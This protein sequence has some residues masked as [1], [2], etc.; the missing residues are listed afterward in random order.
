MKPEDIKP[1]TVIIGLDSS[2]AATVVVVTPLSDNAWEIVYRLPDRSIRDRM[3]SSEDVA[4]FEE[5]KAGH[6]FGF[7]ADPANFLLTCE[8]KRMDLAFLFDPMMAI[9]TSNVEPLPHQISAVYESMLPRQPLRYV[10]ADDPGA[11]KTIMAGLYMREMILR[12]DAIRILIVAPGSLVEQWRDELYEKFSLQFEVFTGNSQ[13]N[14]VS[15]FQ[16]K[17]QWI[18]RL[19]Q[20]VRNEV[21]QQDLLKEPWDLVIFD[22]AHKL[23]A[24]AN[25]AKIQETSRYKLG[26]ELAKVT[27]H[28]LLMTATP[29][30]GKEADF[31]LFLKLLDED[32]FY[33]KFRDGVHQI[34]PSDLMRRMVKEELVKFDGT[35]LFPERKAY[36][37]NYSLSSAEAK[38]YGLVTQYV[39]SEMGKA[40]QIADGSKRGAVGFALT[41]LQRRLASSP[42]AIYKSLQR[43]CDRHT[44]RLKEEALGRRAQEISLTLEDEDDYTAEELEQLSGELIDRASTAESVQELEREIKILSQLVELAKT[45]NES[46][47]D[48][49]WEELSRI[50]QNDSFMRDSS[51]NRRKIIVFTEHRDTL[52]YLERKISNLLGRPESVA[53]I[54]GGTNRDE[55]RKIQALFRS[56]PDL[57]VLLATDAA[58]E[59]VNLQCACLMVNYDLPWNPNRMEQRFGRIHRI[60]QTEVCHLWSLVA[61]E[62]REGAVWRRLLDKIA[63]ECEALRGKVFNILGEIFEDKPLKDLMI[64]AIRYGELPEVREKLNTVI[65]HAFDPDNLRELLNRNALAEDVMSQENLYRI[66]EEM[67][68]AEA[69]KLQPYY[70][71]LFFEQAAKSL[72]VSLNKRSGRRLEVSFVPSEIRE[73]DRRITGRSRQNSEPV[74]KKYELICFEKSDRDAT[75]SLQSRAV[76]MHPG[77]PLMLAMTDLVLERN[78]GILRQGTILYQ[79]ASEETRPWILVLLSHEVKDGQ[80][81]LL[82]RR[83]QF[84]R[85]DEDGSITFAGYAPHLDLAPIPVEY[86][87]SLGELGD[88]FQSLKSLQD[89][90]IQRITSLLAKEHYDEIKTRHVKQIDKTL[91]AIH[92]RLR[93]EID[94]LTD[95]EERLREDKAAG[96]DVH[97]LEKVQRDLLELNFRLESRS[98]ELKQKRDVVNSTPQILGAALVLPPGFFNTVKNPEQKNRAHIEYLAM[99]AVRYK[100]EQAGHTVIDVSKEHCG[101]DLTSLPR[102]PKGLPRHIEVKGRAYGSDTVTLTR[103]E[104][105]Y[106]LN[107]GD[108]FILAIVLVHPDDTVAGPYYIHKPFKNEPEAGAVSINYHLGDLL[109]KAKVV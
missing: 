109:K 1:G 4:D 68:K 32:R 33:G 31:Q 26:R 14:Y 96:K 71:R 58:G 107:Q 66:K 64:E 84:V 50:L 67:E 11:G 15:P 100:E 17:S 38:L 75:D 34:D 87:K 21:Y 86:A 47:T 106:A 28:L 39:E 83:L 23:S 108:K 6:A 16:D 103:N 72:D 24:H 3:V 13:L 27:R 45:L 9:H 7:D 5:Q 69:R 102:D 55:R 82:S 19:D 89:S 77:H 80:H 90:E 99:Q 43:R 78:L 94:F 56:D 12:A 95:R 18:V 105:L 52:S 51:R 73:R 40:D 49:K 61:S 48:R 25:G 36:T 91:Y 79:P 81:K 42:E 70:V 76:L 97:G 62:T 65:D 30:N 60:G 41:S 92:E 63:V 10:L 101:W 22:E 88:E 93:K 37:A 20:M 74:L 2:G 104:I 53:C 98:K 54:H 29:H 46:G 8:A 59:G 35:P 44:D 85:K 57:L